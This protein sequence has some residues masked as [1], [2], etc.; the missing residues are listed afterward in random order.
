MQFYPYQHVRSWE[1]HSD[2]VIIE[3]AK[4]R[5]DGSGIDREVVKVK[6]DQESCDGIL[7]AIHTCITR[8]MERKKAE[9]AA[10]ATQAASGVQG[11]IAEQM[12]KQESAQ[13]S[14]KPAAKPQSQQERFRRASLVVDVAAMADFTAD[15]P[16][17]VA[18]KGPLGFDAGSTTSFAARRQSVLAETNRRASLIGGIGN[19]LGAAGGSEADL[20]AAAVAAMDMEDNFDSSGISGGKVMADV[21]GVLTEDDEVDKASEQ[22]IR[23]M[24]LMADVSGES[25][26]EVG[27][28]RERRASLLLDLAAFIEEGE[29][30][31]GE[32]F[33][34]AATVN[35]DT[36]AEEDEGEYSDED[37]FDDFDE[38]DDFDDFHGSA[39][40][41]FDLL[42]VPTGDTEII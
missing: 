19:V 34:E 25:T 10:Q 6:A 22:G 16:D 9:K 30:E 3:V 2:K 26:P 23:R 1:N 38:L 4:K 28:E 14:P 11:A 15:E 12:A 18:K 42:G 33:E 39:T 41:D 20:M 40:D 17:P 36:I 13:A 7:K 31:K 27:G 8:L 24:S 29:E 35:F 21:V 37:E 5:A 32:G